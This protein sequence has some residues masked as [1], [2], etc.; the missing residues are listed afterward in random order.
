MVNLPNT[1]IV[2]AAKSGTTSLYNYLRQHPDIFMSPVKEPCYF[3]YAENPPA[4]AGPGDEAANR[5]SGVVYTLDAYQ[6][7]FAE[8]T[9]ESIVGEA[10]PV[11]L[12]DEDAP[13]LLHQHCP[14]ATLIAILRNPV[15]RAYSHYLQL[16]QSGRESLERF[17][18]ALDAEDE[19]RDAGWEWSWHYRHMG[20]YGR[21]L[22]RYLEYFDREQLHVY[23]FEEL[24][25]DPEGFA[26]TV[27][28]A[29]G[30]GSSF[31]PGTG[32]RHRATGVPQLDWLHQFIGTPDHFLRRWSRLVLPEAVRDRILM[33]V[34]N[35]NLQKP[36]LSDA[37]RARLT[38]A[39]RDDVHRL[40][41]LLDQSFSDWLTTDDTRVADGA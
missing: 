15:D 41:T 38:D 24:T 10:S 18:A 22:A 4:L 9:S 16:V 27:Y 2:G 32:I 8:A 11:Y 19:R 30:V 13:R 40:E 29:L 33:A 21:Q 14:D 36:P 7:L 3:A 39:Y 23:R 31:E 1:F 34:R 35:A 12:Y 28:R 6:E 17:E 26:Q 20:F 25:K 5:E 37:A